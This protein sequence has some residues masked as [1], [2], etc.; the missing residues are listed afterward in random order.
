[1]KKKFE[2]TLEL[3]NGGYLGLGHFQDN[4]TLTAVLAAPSH[5]YIPIPLLSLS[6]SLVLVL[7]DN[8][9]GGQ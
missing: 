1:M 9:I 2:G 8:D 7:A 4:I 3:K 5:G 6:G